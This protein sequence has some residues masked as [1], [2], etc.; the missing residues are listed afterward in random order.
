MIFGVSDSMSTSMDDGG[1]PTIRDAHP[2]DVAQL[3]SFVRG[4]AE[5][6]REQHQVMAT[7]ADLA[8]ALFG[9]DPKVFALVAE[10]AGAVVGMLIYF[11]SFSTWTGRHGLYVEDLF[12]VPGQRRQGTGKALLAALAVR[13]VHTGCPRI[14]WVVLD[15]NQPA[16]DFYL[17]LGA[18]PMDEWR[19]FRLSD[20]A[21]S[22]LAAANAEERGL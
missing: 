13:A 12:I 2:G 14:E 16:I 8:E 7:E 5:Y 3:L 20:E 6:E 22:E 18:V 17:S 19:T 21:L 10:N 15:W 1:R 9:A 11:V 4:L